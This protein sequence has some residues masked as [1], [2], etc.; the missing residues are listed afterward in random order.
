MEVGRALWTGLSLRPFPQ[1]QREGASR[2]GPGAPP[3]APPQEKETP[4]KAVTEGSSDPTAGI[5]GSGSWVSSGHEEKQE[6]EP[7]AVFPQLELQQD[8]WEKGNKERAGRTNF[9]VHCLLWMGKEKA[10]IISG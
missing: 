9:L 3:A 5:D 10:K 7:R 4:G 2:A 1:C 8:P 6:K